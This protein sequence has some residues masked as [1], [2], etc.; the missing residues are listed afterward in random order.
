M[1][2]MGMGSDGGD[3]IYPRCDQRQGCHRPDVPRVRPGDRIR[4][5][6]IN[7]AA[8]TIFTVAWAGTA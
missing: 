1:G 7:A 8:D 6:I 4:V 2:G 5:R 3:V